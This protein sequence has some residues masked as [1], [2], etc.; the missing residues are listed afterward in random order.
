[1]LATYRIRFFVVLLI[2][3]GLLAVAL[4][5]LS[6]QRHNRLAEDLV[7]LQD[8][9]F[10]S[11]LLADELRQSS[12]DLTRL[13]RTYVLTADP[14][15]EAQYLDILAIRNGE[16]ER[17]LNYNR[18]Y[19]DFLAAGRP[20][21]GGSGVTRALTDLM[22]DA[23]FTEAEFTLLAQAQA[24]S[25]GLVALEVQAMNAVKGLFA[26]A[27]GDY[28][29]RGPP[30]MEL[31][32]DLLHSPQYHAFKADIMEPLNGFLIAMEQRFDTVIASVGAA[33]LR[34]TGWLS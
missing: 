27:A 7:L 31:A 13:A 33:R 34:P 26:D 29:L 6:S 16:K 5:F 25:D 12:D 3:A 21:P 2:L 15:Y 9:R 18:V 8:Q 20:V 10:A 11:Y 28:V 24:N 22:A 14:A 23:G 32:R 4:Q 30:D 19:W 1:M 17:P